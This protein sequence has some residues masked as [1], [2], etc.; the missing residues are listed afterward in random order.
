MLTIFSVFSFICPISTYIP[1]IFVQE[2]KKWGSKSITFLYADALEKYY[3]LKRGVNCPLILH[4]SNEC[5]R[6]SGLYSVSAFLAWSTSWN[7]MPNWN[8]FVYMCIFSGKDL[9]FISSLKKL[10]TPQ[11]CCELYFV[12][13]FTSPC[14][15]ANPQSWLCPFSN[16]TLCFQMNLVNKHSG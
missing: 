2:H 10:K 14:G 13:Y 8:W 5:Y 11:K 1:Y 4:H 9:Y 12:S 15:W 3:A 6:N 7:C 16:P